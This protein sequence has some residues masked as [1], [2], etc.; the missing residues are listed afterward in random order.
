MHVKEQFSIIFFVATV[1]SR[2]LPSANKE[3]CSA[4]SLV[5]SK[6]HGPEQPGNYRHTDGNQLEHGKNHRRWVRVRAT[7]P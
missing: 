5:A 2:D 3:V 6:R 7:G 1:L 4:R